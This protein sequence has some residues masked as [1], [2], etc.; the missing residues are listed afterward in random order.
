MQKRRDIEKLMNSFKKKLQTVIGD[1]SS[2]VTIEDLGE[3]FQPLGNLIQ[4]I[5]SA[6][7]LILNPEK[8]FYC[9]QALCDHRHIIESLDISKNSALQDLED[10]LDKEENEVLWRRWWTW[11]YYNCEAWS[12]YY[13]VWRLQGIGSSIYPIRKAALK[14]ARIHY[15]YDKKFSYKFGDYLHNMAKTATVDNWKATVEECFMI[16]F[17]KANKMAFKRAEKILKR[18]IIDF[19]YESI[20]GKIEKMI[21]GGMKEIIGPLERSIPDPIN[22]LLDLNTVVSESVQKALKDSVE[23]LVVEGI[24]NPF[25]SQISTD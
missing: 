16:G 20:A 2:K 24:I 23:E 8:Q 1:L 4:I 13:N 25:V 22:K 19:F 21:I 12:L 18:L 14:F 7:N 17:Q 9:L 15:D 5:E 3:L 11:Y 6:F 10:Y